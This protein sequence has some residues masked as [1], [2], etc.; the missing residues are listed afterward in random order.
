MGREKLRAGHSSRWNGRLGGPPRE[1]ARRVGRGSKSSARRLAI[2]APT[3]TEVGQHQNS[4]LGAHP[5]W[6]RSVATPNHPPVGELITAGE[7]S[8]PP[9]GTG[10]RTRSASGWSGRR[11]GERQRAPGAG[12]GYPIWTWS[13]L[14]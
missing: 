3:A 2:H 7:K 13:K 5:A 9:K 12:R 4:C 11:A 14:S 8:S 10:R 6:N 1:G